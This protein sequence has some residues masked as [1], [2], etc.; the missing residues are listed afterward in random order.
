MAP[1][2]RPHAVTE[3]RRDQERR[4]RTERRDQPE[5]RDQQERRNRSKKRDRSQ[6]CDDDVD[7]GMSVSLKVSSY[8]MLFLPD[9][10][11]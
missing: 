7:V 4:S 9:S 1:L 8:F 5:K 6:K 11:I 3:D 2:R 10:A